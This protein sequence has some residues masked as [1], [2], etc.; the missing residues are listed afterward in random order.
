MNWMNKLF[1][2]III[3]PFLMGL[4][5]ILWGDLGAEP[6]KE[7]K[8]LSGLTGM[9]Y[10]ALNLWIGTLSAWIKPWPQKILF[11]KMERRFLGVVT[12]IILTT[13]VFFYFVLEAFEAN[14]LDQIFEKTY[15]I[16]GGLAYLGLAVL[17]ITSN[18]FSM[19]K[20]GG[21]KWK[22]IHRSIY[23]IAALVTSHV[24]LIEKANLPLFFVTWAP[25]WIGL[26]GR[27]LFSL[28]EKIR[29]PKQKHQI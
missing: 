23:V 19:R 9:F 2:W 20:L 5:L 14:A 7:L 8:H 11:L 21:K 29:G 24:F 25:L 26:A 27:L 17:A 10:L 6:S 4:Y 3:L 15:L 12:F 16:F 1:R 18:N 28:N 22:S 13:H